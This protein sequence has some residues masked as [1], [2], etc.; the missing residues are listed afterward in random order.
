MM[1]H[2]QSRT[3]SRV[4]AR[5]CNIVR[6]R[7]CANGECLLKKSQVCELDCQLALCNAEDRKVL[8]SPV[9]DSPLTDNP[10]TNN[11]PTTGHLSASISTTST[12]SRL[13]DNKTDRRPT[14]SRL[15]TRGYAGTGC[16][17]TGRMSIVFIFG[18]SAFSSV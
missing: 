14:A 4:V 15:G 17:R 8:V 1:N 12:P 10:V 13:R 11:L 5:T 18:M 2:H 3:R 16:D 9:T 6:S 7:G